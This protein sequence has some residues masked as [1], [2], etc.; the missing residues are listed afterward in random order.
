MD[1]GEFSLRWNIGIACDVFYKI[2]SQKL[3][4]NAMS[5]VSFKSISYCFDLKF[6]LLFLFLWIF[7]HGYFI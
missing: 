5:I 3:L 6:F 1:L 7:D 2:S 4:F